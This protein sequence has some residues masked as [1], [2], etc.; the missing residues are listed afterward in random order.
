MSPAERVRAKLKAMLD[1]NIASTAAKESHDQTTPTV[2]PTPEQLESIE[3]E[4]FT[5]QSFQ[6]Q[7]TPGKQGTHS[8]APPARA[9]QS[10]PG[11]R[12]VDPS[13]YEPQVVVLE[14][15]SSDHTPD[16]TQE[17]V[18]DSSELGGSGGP[19]GKAQVMK[20]SPCVWK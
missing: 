5:S 14:E 11:S 15:E 2:M 8:P 13:E 3:S 7:R 12:E 17:D 20:S 6:S 10:Q 1:K 16:H 18:A 19:T 4:S 9:S